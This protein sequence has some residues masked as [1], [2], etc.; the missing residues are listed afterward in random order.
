MNSMYLS[1]LWRVMVKVS[2]WVIM[3]L[4]AGVEM[5][6]GVFK[7]RGRVV[8][9]DRGDAEN[10]ILEGIVCVEKPGPEGLYQFVVRGSS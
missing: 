6:D 9:V 4:N 2:F 8:T 1:A 5:P 7:S 10:L 3:P